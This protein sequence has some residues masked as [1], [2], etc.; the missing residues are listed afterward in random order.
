MLTGMYPHRLEA[1]GKSYEFHRY[2]G[3]GHAF[4]N[5]ANEER[6]RE[7]ASEDAW[8]KAIAF[9]DRHLKA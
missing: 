2:D 4:Q 6:Y 5:F 9:L 7:D 8:A 3:A 1:G